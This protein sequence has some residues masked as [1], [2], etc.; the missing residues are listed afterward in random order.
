M[1]KDTLKISYNICKASNAYIIKNNGIFSIYFEVVLLYNIVPLAHIPFFALSV[2]LPLHHGVVTS[3]NIGFF[4]T[5]IRSYTE[6]H[7]WACSCQWG[8]SISDV[9]RIS[10]EVEQ[11]D[12]H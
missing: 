9:F 7:I 8:E 11:G 2:L 10:N 5:T 3:N 1:S 12:K 6:Q 4:S